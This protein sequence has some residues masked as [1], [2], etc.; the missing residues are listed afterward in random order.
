MPP[1]SETEE[2]S[3]RVREVLTRYPEPL[4]RL[5][6]GR[7]IKPRLNQPIDELIE[8]SV[9]TL[10]NPP[11]VDR[12]IRELPPASRK[13]IALIG[14]SR[15]PRWKVGHLITALSALGH[16]EGFAPIEALLEA[17]LICPELSP[18]LTFPGE[19]A[20]W[21]GQAGTLTA[22]VFAHPGVA[23][24]ARGEDLEL[25]DLSDPEHETSH[26]FRS[27]D[28]LEWPLRLAAV[29]QQVHAAPVR[30]TLAS[31][32]FKKDQSRLQVDEVLASPLADQLAPAPDGG[33]LALYWARAAQLLEDADGELRA[34]DFPTAWNT[35][36]VAV[37]TQ[38][39]AALPHVETWDPLA[40]YAPSDN[41]LS[42]FPSASLLA[43][44]LCRKAA[45]VSPAAIATWLWE[46]HPS[47]AGTLPTSATPDRGAE[48]VH[49]FL[50]GLAFPLGLIESDG[51]YVRLSALG[52][53]LLAGG[54]EPTAPPAFPQTLLVQPNAEVLA[55]RQG[56]TPA[57]IGMLTRFAR[58]KGIGP[59][60]TLELTPEQTY[61]G[62][63]S[64]LTLPMMMQTLNRHGTRPVPASVEDLLQRW[65]N[66]RERITVFS[67]AVLVEFPT[68]ADLDAAVNRGVVSLRLTDRVGM[69][70]D[71]TEP[72]LS[73]LRLLANRDYESK[74]QRC[75]SVAEDG[76]TLIVDAAQSD[77]LLEAEIGRFAEPAPYESPG[78]R[79]FRLSPPF[80]RRALEQGLTLGD[81]DM[82]FQERS[83]GPLS[84]TGRLFL[85]G[86]KATAPTA[87]NLLVVRLPSAE[88][89]DGLMQWPDTRRLISERLGP[90]TLSIEPEAL[91]PLKEVLAE[92]HVNLETAAQ[93]GEI[94]ANNP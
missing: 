65:S 35:G 28:G 14:L 50:L 75:V 1:I 30:L 79:R 84:A 54:P 25:P 71:G 40:G 36:L 69:T 86:P 57:L 76:I 8:K 9:S 82:W 87:E 38:L 68:P 63:E 5:V 49:N 27:A 62:L 74:P 85:L 61:R 24:R 20:A 31:T 13:A 78:V 32:L 58:W 81:I 47:W 4:L 67:S 3:D 93:P 73:Q 46:H 10:G 94:L 33:I 44:L 22:M 29:W 41:G 51:E 48:W 21:Y 83:G 77:L 12:R 23:S 34:S 70:A 59:A 72:G 26:S 42:P 45:V 39:V 92:V 6:A 90:T 11:I 60:C 15:Q 66:K 55:Y 2:W 53:H 17:G 89:A 43:L 16:P 56:L 7:L 37:L 64:G 80:L 18:H 88:L 52:K 91:G 19:F